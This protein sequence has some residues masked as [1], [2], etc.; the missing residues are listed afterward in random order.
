VA[1]VESFEAGRQTMRRRLRIWVAVAPV[2]FVVP[3][4]AAACDGP[5]GEDDAASPAVV[6]PIKGTNSKRIILTQDA[7]R[8]LGIHTV[9]VRSR[10][11]GTQQTV[12]P[13]DAVLYDAN[14]GG[15]TYTNPRPLVFERAQIRIAEIEGDNAILAK[16]PAVGT[17]VVTVGAPEIWGVEYGGI[18]DAPAGSGD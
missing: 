16:G 13:Y 8:R 11:A 4:V 14:G 7:A 3:L 9:A 15:W 10:T 6:E 17:P 1:E 12:I 5:S 18:E 2:L